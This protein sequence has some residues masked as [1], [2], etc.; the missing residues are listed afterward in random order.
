MKRPDD[1][2]R[3]CED[4]AR[5]TAARQRHETPGGLAIVHSAELGWGTGRGRRNTAAMLVAIHGEKWIVLADEAPQTSDQLCL[6]LTWPLASPWIGVKLLSARRT[7]I[8]PIQ[9]KLT[10]QRQVDGALFSTLAGHD[11]HGN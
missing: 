7:R 5:R 2:R 6:R 10:S 4:G 11:L 8:G 9:L 3:S 1:H